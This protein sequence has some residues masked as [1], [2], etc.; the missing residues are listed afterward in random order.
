[1]VD[2]GGI[3]RLFTF[4]IEFNESCRLWAVCTVCKHACRESMR[5][6]INIIYLPRKLIKARA[7]LYKLCS[8]SPSSLSLLELFLISPLSLPPLVPFTRTLQPLQSGYAS[9]PTSKIHLNKKNETNCQISFS[10]VG[11]I[12]YSFLFPFLILYFCSKY[13]KSQHFDAVGIADIILSSLPKLLNSHRFLFSHLRQMKFRTI[14]YILY[15]TM[16]IRARPLLRYTTI[17]LLAA[18]CV[19]VFLIWLVSV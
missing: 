3:D 18:I 12:K 10:K 13:S 19:S 2:G 15:P 4:R 17:F 6:P 7:A 11:Q 1:M 16:N 5:S 9:S 8:G 14:R